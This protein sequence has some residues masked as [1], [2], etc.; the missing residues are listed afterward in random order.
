MVPLCNAGRT[1]YRGRKP[2]QRF[3]P[4]HGRPWRASDK[5]ARAATIFTHNGAPKALVGCLGASVGKY[6]ADSGREGSPGRD[7]ASS[8]A[9]LWIDGFVGDDLLLVM[10]T[11]ELSASS[12]GGP[13]VFG[14]RPGKARQFSSDRGRDHSR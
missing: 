9:Q 6:P 10:S 14:D 13:N 11:S 7:R 3:Q 1:V 8:L 4:Q 2:P 5:P 12:G